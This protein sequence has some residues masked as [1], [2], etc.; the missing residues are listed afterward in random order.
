MGADGLLVEVHHD[1]DH[2]LSDGAQSIFPDQFD[3]LM[4]EVLFAVHDYLHCWTYGLLRARFPKLGAG[5]AAIRA[6]NLEAT[7]KR[8]KHLKADEAKVKEY[9]ALIC[10]GWD[11]RFGES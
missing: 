3:Q 2:A 4:S 9:Q 6:D 7:I 10:R 5:S 8:F 11:R 1:P